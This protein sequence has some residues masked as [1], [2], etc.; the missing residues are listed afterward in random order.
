MGAVTT[1]GCLV[2]LA[3]KTGSKKRLSRTASLGGWSV[4]LRQALAAKYRA[5]IDFETNCLLDRYLMNALLKIRFPPSD[6]HRR[7]IRRKGRVPSVADL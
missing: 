5:W 7:E 2:I 3:G 6:L 1:T 4:L